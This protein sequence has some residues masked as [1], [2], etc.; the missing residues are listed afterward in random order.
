MSFFAKKAQFSK[1]LT[2]KNAQKAGFCLQN[3]VCHN[4]FLLGVFK[5]NV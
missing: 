4:R 5:N 1:Q 2:S 3:S